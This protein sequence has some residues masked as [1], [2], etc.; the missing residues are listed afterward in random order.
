MLKSGQNLSQNDTEISRE[1][2]MKINQFSRLNMRYHQSKQEI[3]ALKEELEN[4]IDAGSA[5]EEAMGDPLKLFIGEA[6]IDVDESTAENYHEKLT[7]EKQE[8]LEH[9]NDGLEE[10]ETEMN[11]LKS[12]LYARFG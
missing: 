2:Q 4:L 8:D 7:E 9:M 11:T 10:I 12:F 5:I 1:D 3:K 6:L